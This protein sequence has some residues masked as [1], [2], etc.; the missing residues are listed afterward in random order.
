MKKKLILMTMGVASMLTF[1][2]APTQPDWNAAIAEY[3]NRIANNPADY[4]ARLCH[5]MAI[6]G[7]QS[8]N[9]VFQKF[10]SSFGFNLVLP[11]WKIS[12]EF[13]LVQAMQPNAIFDDVRSELC[14]AA[15]QALDDLNAIPDDWTG[16]VQLNA[17]VWPV[18]DSDTFVDIADVMFVR[19]LF[20]LVLSTVDFFASYDLPVDWANIQD[21]RTKEV[22]DPMNGLFNKVRNGDTLTTS[23]E[24]FR[25]ALTQVL[26]ADSKVQNRPEGST[27]H[28]IDYGNGKE[29]DI[30]REN[31]LR[32]LASLDG[33]V[34][35][36]VVQILRDLGMDPDSSGIDFNTL[37]PGGDSLT[38]Y[39][40]AFYDGYLTR[41]A[42]PKMRLNAE[43]EIELAFNI[44]PSQNLYGLLPG[45]NESY[46]IEWCKFL[47]IKWFSAHEIEPEDCIVIDGPF[48]APKSTI[49]V[50]I[51]ISDYSPQEALS[52]KVGKANRNGISKL[53][54]TVTNK[55]GKK[56]TGRTAINTSA[57]PVEFSVDVKKYGTL[58]L[59][60]SDKGFAGK[61]GTFT[62]GMPLRNKES[63][64][65]AKLINAQ[66]ESLPGAMNKYLPNREPVQRTVKKWKV[67][68]K[69]GK[70]SY[71]KRKGWT[72]K[73]DNISALK[74]TYAPKTAT[75]KGSFKVWTFDEAKQRLK[76][77][78]VK[79]SGVTF[80]GDGY[81]KVNFKKTTIGAFKVK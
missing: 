63:V 34:T 40:G 74:L 68:N 66:L 11:S 71:N 72:I 18:D 45:M 8:E 41:D 28:L 35:F 59:V 16:Y 13:S 21:I 23:K 81:G 54:V 15:R 58:T 80:G 79:V 77:N 6:I 30:I 76:G 67:V 62:A 7:K 64:A 46:Y 26:A 32:L 14:P 38:L 52:I 1:G 53:M 65:T 47:G 49:F 73:G 51:T 20:N 69:A 10:A 17:E 57:E 27:Y 43:N 70:I 2:G 50:G 48:T 24:Y 12:G 42:L 44:M 56:F 3:A 22:T 75:F 36:P 60:I 19:S 78:S 29:L 61:L 37:L 31:T 33:P 39:L 25:A 4:E 5:A 55:D 9:P